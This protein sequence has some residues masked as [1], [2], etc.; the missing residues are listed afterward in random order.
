MSQ[1]KAKEELERIKAPLEVA[2][3][4]EISLGIKDVVKRLEAQ[5]PQGVKDE[6]A[7]TVSGTN[8]VPVQPTRTK[9]PYIRATVFNDGPSP[10][11]VFLNDVTPIAFRQ[12]PLNAG[13]K[14][15]IDTTE[16]KIQAL[17]V[18][19]GSPTDQAS[20]RVWLLK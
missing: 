18:V 3:L 17:F 20:G 13:D 1:K 6:V 4:D 19:C 5:V 12:A 2:L 10:V 14:A 15:D 11:Y 8:P 7:F 16:A 9:P